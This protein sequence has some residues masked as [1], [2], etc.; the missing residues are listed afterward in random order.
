MN[1]ISIVPNPTTGEFQVTSYKLRVTKV[2]VFDIYGRKQN[3]EFNSYGFTVLRSY[4]LSN[5]SAGIYFVKITTEQGEIVK[6]IVK[7]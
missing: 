7:Q 4:G 5:L 2:E 1:N 3:V 6:K